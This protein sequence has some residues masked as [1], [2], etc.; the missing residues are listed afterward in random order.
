[1]DKTI[2][3]T[4]RDGEMIEAHT[5][6]KPEVASCGGLVPM[7]PSQGILVATGERILYFEKVARDKMELLRE[8]HY[9]DVAH[10]AVYPDIMYGIGGLIAKVLHLQPFDGEPIRVVGPVAYKDFARLVK[11]RQPAPAKGRVW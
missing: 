4:L 2:K 11:S 9:Q 3:D 1:M 6:G 8:I 5:W 7:F 10:F